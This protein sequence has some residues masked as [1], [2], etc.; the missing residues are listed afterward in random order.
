MM[1]SLTIVL[2]IFIGFQFHQVNTLDD[3]L[4]SFI[5]ILLDAQEIVLTDYRT[6]LDSANNEIDF[7]IR[8]QHS[9]SISRIGFVTQEMKDIRNEIVN[10]IRQREIESGRNESTCI[11]E[12]EESLQDASL[13]GGDMVTHVANQWRSQND[14]LFELIIYP[15]INELEVI[16]SLFEINLLNYFANVNSVTQMYYLLLFYQTEIQTFFDIFEYFVF[17]IYI[18]MIIYDLYTTE[19]NKILF[20]ELNEGLAE[21][22]EASDLIRNSLAESYL[23][24][25]A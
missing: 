20:V 6:L 17:Y 18:D 16:I 19:I 8:N 21:F 9:R 22:R 7:M 2:I 4:L 23:T 3:E 1:K 5:P 15:T 12:V 24:S 13:V 10:E 11:S 25:E 14:Q